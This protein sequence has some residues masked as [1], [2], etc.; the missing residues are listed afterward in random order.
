MNATPATRTSTLP[1]LRYNNPIPRRDHQLVLDHMDYDVLVEQLMSEL[2]PR[3]ALAEHLIHRLVQELLKLQF[4]AKVEFA[5][6]DQA[7]RVACNPLVNPDDISKRTSGKSL[8]DCDQEIAV[9]TR[10]R[11]ALRASESPRLS[12]VEVQQMAVI[13][14]ERIT[15]WEHRCEEHRRLVTEVDSDLKTVTKDEDREHWESER[16]DALAELREDEQLDEQEGCTAHGV[17]SKKDVEEILSGHRSIPTDARRRWE[18]TLTD[19]IAHV[20]EQRDLIASHDTYMQRIRSAALD[21]A[22]AAI[23]RLAPIEQYAS[24]IWKNVERCVKQL[25]M[26]GMNLN[27]AGLK[28]GTPNEE[29]RDHAGN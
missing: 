3:N 20:K 23:P 25:S 4:A 24:G 10:V 9:L 11:A 22:A 26:L 29:A 7:Q 13:L 18:E 8:A 19:E 12:A 28:L 16:Q 17:E 21:G 1:R 27:S 15:I 14:W 6:M 5:L 2:R